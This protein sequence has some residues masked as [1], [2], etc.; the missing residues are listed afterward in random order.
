MTSFDP[1]AATI[2]AMREATGLPCSTKV[3]TE[4]PAAFVT[5]ERTGGSMGHGRDVANLAVQAWAKT[6]L[7]A[8]QL[9]R[10]CALAALG[11][12]E[13]VPQVC[14]VEVSGPYEFGD[15]ESGTPRHQVDLY[16]TCRL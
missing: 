8:S 2:A 9:A 3:P 16:L 6:D 4:R 14:R 15:P 12:R 10:A 11:M 13:A 1:V 7:A 5:V